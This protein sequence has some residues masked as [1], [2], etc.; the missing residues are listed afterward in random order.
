LICTLSLVAATAIAVDRAAP[1]RGCFGTYAG[2]PKLPDGHVGQ[3]KLLAELL[4]IHANTYHWLFRGKQIEFDDFKT[5]LPLAAQ[6]KIKLWVTLVPPSETL[7]KAP[8][9]R[10][11]QSPASPCGAAAS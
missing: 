6:H 2:A 5:Y 1:L 11:L 8:R 3:Q 9:L 7:P 4:D 10:R